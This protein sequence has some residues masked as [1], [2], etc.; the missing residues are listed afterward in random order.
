MRGSPEHTHM[1]IQ[2]DGYSSGTSSPRN[3]PI[4]VMNNQ[5]LTNT[6]QNIPDK[7]QIQ[8]MKINDQIN[9]S[10]H[11]RSQMRRNT[12]DKVDAEESFLSTFHS[13]MSNPNRLPL[14]NNHP[15]GDNFMNSKP[16]SLTSRNEIPKDGIFNL[17]AN[18]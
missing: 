2:N 7:E 12:M 18:N 11:M 14:V 15:G 9:M 17:Q 3:I 4:Q 5:T 16:M 13:N 10:A 1:N 8:L 6:Y